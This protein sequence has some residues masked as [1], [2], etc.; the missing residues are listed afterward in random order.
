MKRRIDA[1]PG[2]YK[3]GEG[4]MMHKPGSENRKK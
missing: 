4:L 1:Y 3:P 2:E